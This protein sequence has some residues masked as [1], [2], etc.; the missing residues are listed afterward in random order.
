MNEKEKENVK[1]EDEEEEEEEGIWVREQR[2]RKRKRSRRR[3]RRE[4]QL[5]DRLDLAPASDGGQRQ[6][7]EVRGQTSVIFL[8]FS[9]VGVSEPCQSRVGEA[10]KKRKET[11]AGHR[12]QASR[13]RTGVRH[14]HD[15]KNGVSVQPRDHVC[16]CERTN[17]PL[18]ASL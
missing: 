16:E 5:A 10:R 12:N 9:T 17:F 8:F 18:V 11:L 3:R 15:A 2:K 6:W 4:E 14:R 7:A 13:T 1:E